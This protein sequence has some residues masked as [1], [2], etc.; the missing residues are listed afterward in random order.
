MF[1]F[2]LD[3]PEIIDKHSTL[4]NESEKVILSRTIDSNPLADVLWYSGQLLLL[5]QLSV[6]N[7]TFTIEKASCTDTKKFTLVASNKVQ[8]NVTALVELIVNCELC[9]RYH[10]IP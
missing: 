3:K 2:F 7:A 9:V 1:W 10:C 5:S 8:R 4:V 6:K